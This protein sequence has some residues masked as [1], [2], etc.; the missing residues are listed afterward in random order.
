MSAV[1]HARPAAYL[2]AG[3]HRRDV[4]DERV[5]DWPYGDEEQRQDAPMR[6]RVWWILPPA[7]L[8][9]IVQWR[10]RNCA[11]FHMHDRTRAYTRSIIGGTYRTSPL[12]TGPTATKSNGGTHQ[13]GQGS[14]G[15]LPPGALGRIVQWRRRSCAQFCMHDRTRAYTR[16]I[17]GETY[18]TSPLGTGPTATKYHGRM[19]LCGK[20]SG[21]T[22]SPA[23]RGPDC[24]GSPA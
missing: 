24:V 18:R 19:H 17:I 4:P 2:H 16:S 6:Q 7:V 9:R 22:L 11:Q 14:G 13:C 21:E 10:R 15:L 5:E 23:A 12:G 8:S 1:P 3:N 20:E